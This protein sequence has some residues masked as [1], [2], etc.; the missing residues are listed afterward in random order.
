MI[1]APFFAKNRKK[2]VELVGEGVFVFAAHTK[3]Q[4]KADSEYR[5]SQDA[6][7]WYLSGI[8][9]PDW[10]LIVDGFS[11]KSYLVQPE[12]SPVHQLFT[13]FLSAEQAVKQSGVDEVLHPKQATQLLK[14]LAE[15]HTCVYGIEPDPYAKYYDFSPNPAPLKLW[16]RLRTLF[17]EVRSCRQS[18]SQLR[19]RKSPEEIEAIKCSIDLTAMAFE[20]VR[21]GMSE[22]SHEYELEAEFSYR[23]RRHNAT[24]A[25]EPIVA[26]GARAC[27]LHYTTNDA[28]ISRSDLVLID[29][30]ASVHGYNA[31]I[32]RTYASNPESI[33]DRQRDVHDAVVRAHRDIIAII[34]PGLSLR[35]YSEYVDERMKEALIGLGLLSDHADH[36]T[37]RRYFPHAISHGLG[38]DVHESFGGYH[39]FQE[40]MVFTIE[41]GIYIPEEGIGVRIED[42]LL[43]GETGH[44]N[45]S[46]TITIDV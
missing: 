27:T 36:E 8:D 3:L 1:T 31:D 19:A 28:S 16:R 17:E 45:L 10:L 39:E 34:R 11:Q 25:Y 22:F 4:Q 14:R 13:G 29:I 44:E 43:V 33:S 42:D 21:D 20:N 6:S 26:S 32:T 15:K 46:E 24:H 35:E 30:G 12:I 18:L 40:G 37:Y 23:F 5:F 41:P 7:F 2:L 9:Q 38:I